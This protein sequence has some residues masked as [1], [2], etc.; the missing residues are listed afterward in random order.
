MAGSLATVLGDDLRNKV[1]SARILVVGAGGIGCELLKN[2]VLSGFVDIELIDLD[3]IDVSNLNRQFL[4]RSH[5]VGKSKALVAKEIATSFNPRAKITAH[6]GNIKNSQFGLEYFQQ[7]ALVLNALDNVDARKHVNRLCL[8]TNTPLIE[9]GT[10]GYLGQVSVIK[11]GETACYECTPKVTQKQYPICTIRSTPEKMVHCIVWAKECYKLLFGN[12]KD[13]M[14]WEDPT[15]EDKSAFM[16]LCTRVPDLNFDDVTKLQEYSCGVFRGLFDYEIRK[17]LEMKTYMAAAKCPQPLVL[18]EIVGSNI[19]QAINLNDAAV[20]K[21]TDNG[22]VWNDRDVW[23]VS[24][25]VT[26]FVSCIVRILSSEQSRANLGSY[27]FDKD[28]ATAMEFVTAAANLR[29]SVF[30]ISMESLYSCKGIAGNIIPAIATTNA[31]VAGLQVLE[32]FRILQAAKPVG[33]ACKYTDCNRSWN[34]RGELLQPSALEKPNPQCYVCSKHTVEVAVDTNR[35]FLRDLVEKVLK[36][37]LGVNEPTI[38]IGANTIYEEGEDAEMS[39]AVNLEK[40]L[41]D[42]PGKGIHHETTVSIEDFSQDFRCN[43]RVLHRD[44]EEFGGDATELFAL[45][46]DIAELAADLKAEEEKQAALKECAASG[47][48]D[49]DDD[50]FEM[51]KPVEAP[52]HKRSRDTAEDEPTSTKKVK[53][54]VVDLL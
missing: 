4:F 39:L 6:H 30:S 27:E 41:V 48:D 36:K 9:S 33:E 7:F 52:V 25:C 34:A 45:G 31:I 24:E 51:V 3:T 19:V 35:M 23:S 43:I 1:Q 50:D 17:R 22:K 13:S 12:M 49:D 8:A 14:L 53:S 28:D 40:K 38:S 20:K 18:E 5:H 2:L 16:D 47:Y 32:A 11:K 54:D 10:T 46:G 21:Q 44:E 15:N 37:K 29:A 26:R 42:L